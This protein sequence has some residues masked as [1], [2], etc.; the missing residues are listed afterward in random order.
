MGR[1]RIGWLFAPA[2]ILAGCLD[3]RPPAP[4]GSS[5]RAQGDQKRPR[6]FV[7]KVNPIDPPDQKAQPKR[8]ARMISFKVRT[9]MVPLGTVSRS[10]TL[11]RHVREVQV[12]AEKMTLLRKNGFRIAVGQRESWAPIEAILGNTPGLRLGAEQILEFSRTRM[13]T[14]LHANLGIKNLVVFYH[15]AHGG[16]LRGLRF[17]NC[18]LMFRVRNVIDRQFPDHVTIGVVPELRERAPRQRARNIAPHGWKFVDEYDGELIWDLAVQVRLAADEFLLIGPSEA[19]HGAASLIGRRFMVKQRLADVAG[20]PPVPVEFLFV[21]SPT[22][23][24]VGG[25]AE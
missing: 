7:P 4:G 12:G 1:N 25:P 19:V 13:E 9:I 3:S 24:L 17:P 14:E 5:G 22:I 18:S 20:Q 11:W 8:A 6:E 16:G 2:L 15:T 10:Q 23:Q 21:L